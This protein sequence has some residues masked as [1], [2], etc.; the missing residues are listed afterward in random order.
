MPHFTGQHA[1]AL[2]NLTCDYAGEYDALPDGRLQWQASVVAADGAS[3]L[4]TG[5]AT[6][7]PP[8]LV[9]LQAVLAALHAQID[10]QDPADAQRGQG[11]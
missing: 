7:E 6:A 10:A 2:S 8:A 4:F 5:T 11:R 9:G 1:H 3:R